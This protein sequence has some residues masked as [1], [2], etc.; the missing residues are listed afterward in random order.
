[1]SFRVTVSLVSNLGMLCFFKYFMFAAE[2][3]NRMLDVLGKDQMNVLLVLLPAGISFYTFESISY[4][5]DIYY[6]RAKPASVWV[7]RAYETASG[8]P[9]GFWT[10]LK[11]ELKALNAFACYIT[12]FPHLVAGPIIRYQ[13]L[14][15][16]LHERISTFWS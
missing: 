4:N 15:R 12:Q 6:G 16:Q 14:E 13:D 7:R 8:V 1:M 11:L 2:N 5:L 3:V 10:L 9:R